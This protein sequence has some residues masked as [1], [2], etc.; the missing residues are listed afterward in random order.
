MS[1]EDDSFNEFCRLHGIGELATSANTHPQT[2]R[3]CEAF[4]RFFQAGCDRFQGRL[5]Q[6]HRK[7]ISI[8]FNFCSNPS[9]NAF[10]ARASKGR[11]LIGINTGALAV[12]GNAF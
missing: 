11:Y 10:A 9:L 5:F 2:L 8:N 4:K 6:D 1:S 12:L 3:A 7:Q